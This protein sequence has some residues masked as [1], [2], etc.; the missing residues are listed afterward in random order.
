M[1]SYTF[2]YIC[3]HD[4]AEALFRAKYCDRRC[5][6]SRPCTGRLGGGNKYTHLASNLALCHHLLLDTSTFLGSFI[7]DSE[8]LRESQYTDVASG[9]GRARDTQ[10][11]LTLLTITAGCNYDPIRNA[12][13]EIGRAHV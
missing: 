11:N 9:N 12:C 6:W 5:G 8:R 2:L 10:A 1:F 7:A 13:Y 4:V 3:V